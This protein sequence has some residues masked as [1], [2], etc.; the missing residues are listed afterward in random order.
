[1]VAA[2]VGSNMPSKTR[3]SARKAKHIAIYSL[4]KGFDWKARQAILIDP[5]W[6]SENPT[7]RPTDSMG[8]GED[9]IVSFRPLVFDDGNYSFRY[10]CLHT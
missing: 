10:Q 6:D 4:P 2:K 7:L 5:S 8:P 9:L 1:M 3:L